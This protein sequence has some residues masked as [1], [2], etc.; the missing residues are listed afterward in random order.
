M[1]SFITRAISTFI[2]H[3]QRRQQEFSTK[4]ATTQGVRETE[5]P[6][7][8]KGPN[9]D[10]VLGDKVLRSRNMQFADTIYRF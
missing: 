3:G 8:V 4:G 9:P 1:T 10:G 5:V 2:K 6:I 7:G